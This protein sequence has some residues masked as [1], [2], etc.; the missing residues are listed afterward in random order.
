[1]THKTLLQTPSSQQ[2]AMLL[3]LWCPFNPLVRLDD[4]CLCVWD[5]QSSDL[6]ISKKVLHSAVDRMFDSLFDANDFDVETPEIVSICTEF[7]NR[8]SVSEAHHRFLSSTTMGIATAQ[9]HV[10]EN[11]KW[12]LS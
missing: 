1:M 2:E 4:R 5:I 11:N 10:P 6:I 9:V 3:G 7:C 8:V 12:R